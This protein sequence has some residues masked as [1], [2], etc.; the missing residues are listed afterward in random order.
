MAGDDPPSEVSRGSRRP[1]ALAGSMPLDEE[2]IEAGVPEQ[3]DRVLDQAPEQRRADAEVG[4]GDRGRAMGGDHFLGC[5][6]VRLPAGRGDDDPTDSGVERRGDI[7]EHR[8]RGRRFDDDVGGFECGRVVSGSCRTP[9]DLSIVSGAGSRVGDGPTER[10][11]P[12][13]GDRG[14][15]RFLTCCW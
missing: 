1:V 14:H 2:W 12:E 11:V 3:R 4:A 6:A 10:T 8:V 15:Q 13:D 5:A 7:P 9:V